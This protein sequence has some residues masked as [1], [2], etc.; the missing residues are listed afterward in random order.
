[1]TKGEIEQYTNA[2]QHWLKATAVVGS[3]FAGLVVVMALAS[4]DPG[5]RQATAESGTRTKEV[6][7][8]EWREEASKVMSHK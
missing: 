1:M 6:S 2:G 8:A 7:A 5:P 4:S 3:I